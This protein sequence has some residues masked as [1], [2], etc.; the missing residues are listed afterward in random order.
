MA[1]IPLTSPY[2]L[3][4]AVLTIASD[5]FTAAVSKVEFAPSTSATTWRGIGGN[6]LKDQAVAEWTANIDFA[7]DLDPDGLLRYL[8]D[9]EGEKKTA[10]FTPTSGGPTVTATITLSPGAIGG[11]ADGN[12]AVASV[13]LAVDGKPVFADTPAAPVV[14]SASP[15]AAAT[16]AQVVIRG[17]G[18]T[19]ATAVH[20]GAVSVTT[21]TVV[22]AFTIVAI[23]PSGSAGSAAVTVT[24]P[25]GT[26]SALAYT[27]G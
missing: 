14:E 17:T 6:V 19:G 20:F 27:R 15:S 4:N 26:S 3:K 18:F 2:S 23:M 10:V 13:A 12:Y 1:V 16:G 8:L 24:T 21:F 11:G 5:D 25:V 7:Q 22:D 9:N